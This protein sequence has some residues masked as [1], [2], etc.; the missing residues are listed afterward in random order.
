MALA[1]WLVERL[2]LRPLVNQDGL[3]LF[4]ATLGV[5]YFLEGGSQTLFG[6]TSTSSTSASQGRLVLFESV[7]PAASWST[8]STS[9][10]ALIAGVLVAALAIFFQNTSTGRA[11][12]AVADDHQ[13]AQ[14][15]GIPHQ[16]DLVHR[17]ARRRP[18]GAGGGDRVGHQARRAV[19]DHAS[20]R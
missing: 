9:G 3:T 14:S 17:L 6:T 1:A 2:V 12:R 4:M 11:L 13:A 7:F 8:S 5:T 16:P 10:A 15:V 19:L 18:R 20:W